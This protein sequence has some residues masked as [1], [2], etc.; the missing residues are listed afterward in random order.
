MKT[1][2]GNRLQR[3]KSWMGQAEVSIQHICQLTELKETKE[4]EKYPKRLQNLYT[5]IIPPNLGRHCREW[6][7][8]KA[9]AEMNLLIEQKSRNPKDIVIY[10][11][12]SVTKNKSG[13]GFTAKQNGKTIHE[14]SSTYNISTS[15]LTMEIEAVTHALRWLASVD[16]MEESQGFILTDS[17]NLLQ[18]V[19][20]GI[21]TPDWHE[22]MN[23]IKLR[24]LT[25]IYCPGHAGVKGNERADKLAGKAISESSLRLGRSE[26]L[27][28]LRSY[29]QEQ[30]ADHHTI[31][32]LIQNGI[33]RGSGRK[34]SL[35]GKT[36]TIINQ[37]NI[38]TIS[39]TTLRRLLHR[40]M[41]AFWAFPVLGVGEA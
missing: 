36:R 32:R 18:K 28:K 6:P 17:M 26:I 23:T 8:G 5:T 2:K 16:G 12:G 1:A 13:W 3:G 38:G 21:G 35:K 11:D 25:W 9:D 40:G 29:L 20:I 39:K 33:V 10:T 15:S 41:E 4:W 30:T 7:E 14:D 22:A 24:K 37:T 31:D 34:S 19:E 27:R